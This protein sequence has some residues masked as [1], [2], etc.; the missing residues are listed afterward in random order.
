MTAYSPP[1]APGAAA[2]RAG[3]TVNLTLRFAAARTSPCWKPK[4]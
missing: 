2:Q 4:S 3:R 1:G